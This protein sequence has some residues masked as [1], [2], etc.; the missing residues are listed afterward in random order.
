M[1]PIYIKLVS[2]ILKFLFSFAKVTMFSKE[3]FTAKPFPVINLNMK[4]KFFHEELNTRYSFTVSRDK[5]SCLFSNSKS[6]TF[7][8]EENE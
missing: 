7:K 6:P 3:R 1:D 8:A 2:N 5:K 4:Y